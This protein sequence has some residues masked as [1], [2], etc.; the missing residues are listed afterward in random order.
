MIT[1][2]Q[3]INSRVS[4]HFIYILSALAF[5][6]L[7]NTFIF[8]NDSSPIFSGKA[9]TKLSVMTDDAS[10]IQNESIL[11][12][13]LDWYTEAAFLFA[14]FQFQTSTEYNFYSNIKELYLGWYGDFIDIQ[15]GK[16]KVLWGKADGFFITDIVSPKNLS[17]FLTI[18]LDD[19]RIAIPSL[20][21]DAFWNSNKL[22]LVWVPVF[23]PSILPEQNSIWATSS[24]IDDIPL[25]KVLNSP[26]VP[27]KKLD[28]SEVYARY[29]WL[30]TVADIQ[31]VGGWFW[32]DT[33]AIDATITPPIPGGTISITPTYHQI[34]LLGVAGSIPL[35]PLI[36]R[37]EGAYTINQRYFIE[38]KPLQTSWLEKDNITYLVASDISFLEFN[39]SIQWAQDI[40]LDYDNAIKRDE[41]QNHLTVHLN[42]SFFRETVKAE[43]FSNISLNDPSAMIKSQIT[44]MPGNGFQ[45]NFGGWFFFGEEGQF[46]NYKKNNALYVNAVYFF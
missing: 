5:I 15:M 8:P 6:F 34:G 33:P 44:Y 13:K 1:K 24:Q 32:N 43:I 18:E 3:S 29:S 37:G 19:L 42:R 4:L 9:Q 22:E 26:N 11:D 2:A 17:Q 10:I 39:L 12:L 25:T 7:G 27:S 21:I 14:D 20:K 45:T 31:L 23:T 40:I 38:P 46:G 35:G 36:F 41:F 30:G 16:Q 28:N